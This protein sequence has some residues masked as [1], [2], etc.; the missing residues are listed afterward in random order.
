MKTVPL[1][2]DEEDR[3]TFDPEELRK[4]LSRPKAKVLIL[5][6]PH[7]PTGKVFSRHEMEV[8]TE[9]LESL[10]HIVV[11]SDEVYGDLAFDGREHIPF[12]SIGNNWERTVT[13]YSGGKLFNCTGWKVGWSIGPSSLIRL[14]ALISNTIT[15]TQNTPA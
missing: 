8:I 4:V 1:R 7:N 13:L 15:Y 9:I 5:N 6:S 14:G 3:W 11:L 2:C 12:A 10:P